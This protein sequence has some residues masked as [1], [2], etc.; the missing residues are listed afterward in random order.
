MAWTMGTGEGHYADKP[1]TLSSKKEN[2]LLSV[3][4]NGTNIVPDGD[5]YICIWIYTHDITIT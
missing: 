1:A 4:S 2:I 3:L 5:N